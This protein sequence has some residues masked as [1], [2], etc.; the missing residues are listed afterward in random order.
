[1]EGQRVEKKP[2]GRGKKW[3]IAV[4][5]TTG[6]I[7]G[8]YLG[9]CA[10]AGSTDTIFPNVHV[11]GVDV[12]GMTVGQAQLALEHM[13]ST[14]GDDIIATLRYGNWSHSLK[15]GDLDYSWDFAAKC[16]W[17][18][19]RDNFLT[20]GG[21]Y[22]LGLMGKSTH[23]GVPRE[24]E[25]QVLE[26][27]LDQVEDEVGGGV[28][29]ATYQING[30]RLEMTKGVSGI[31]LDRDAVRGMT[32]D[33]LE[34]GMVKK[35]S[36]R[37]KGPVEVE[38]ELTPEQIPP[39]EPDFQ[40]IYQELATKPQNAT[41]DP[42]SFEVT[43]HVVGVDFSVSELEQAYHQAQEG[44]SFSIPVTITQPRDTKESLQGKLF[45]HLLGEAKTTLTGTYG[46]KY[47]VKLAAE[48]CNNTVILPGEV[49]SF[50]GVT[51]SR[52]GAMGYQ[53]ATVYSGGKTI[54]EVGGGVCQTSS[55][56]YY[57]LLH[58]SLEVVQRANH[59][60]NTGYVPVGMDA[61][62]Y[63]GV[64]DF[65]FRNNTDYPIKVV[66]GPE[67]VNGVEVLVCRIYGTN[68]DGVYAVPESYA[69]DKKVPTT[70]YRPDETIPKGTTKVDM[71]QNPYTGLKAQTYRYIYDKD[72]NLL[73]KQDMGVSVY[74][75][76]PKTI[77]YNPADGDPETW[78]DGVP[79]KTPETPPPDQ[80]PETPPETDPPVSPTPDPDPIDPDPIEP[81]T[82]IPD[83]EEDSQLPPDAGDGS[84]G[85]SSDGSS[86]EGGEN[87]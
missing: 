80:K 49:F 52:S 26:Q 4:G 71:V 86:T 54:E 10:W 64:T 53:S 3:A 31:G 41:I 76:R 39:Q 29:T 38:L 44:E 57:A 46:R 87:G 45:A 35:F 69:Y 85:D 59:G 8:A 61:T 22:L 60:Y 47:N 20:G 55:T 14:Y 27:M 13:T 56:I 51:G 82:D 66:I 34:G 28:T 2:R 79:P 33:V 68:E 24:N 58:S 84:S 32:L 6:V 63:Y 50:N 75:M 1:M 42:K 18:T 23:I 9:V 16:A 15:A 62:V 81:G 12:S 21:T 72:G 43:D 7:L 25:S 77:L 48:A 70:V 78:A 67:W 30:D 11:A 83:G 36:H 17:E 65:Q 5:V 73:E 74:K 37:E 19:G 40:A